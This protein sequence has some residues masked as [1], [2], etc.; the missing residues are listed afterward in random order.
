M[1]TKQVRPE[2]SEFEYELHL[3]CKCDVISK[4]NYLLFAFRTTKIFE[5][6]LYKINVT[7][8]ENLEN[9]KIAFNV[10]GLSAPKIG[11]EKYGK[12][13]FDYKLYNLNKEPYE[14]KLFRNGKTKTIY[15][16]KLIKNKITFVKK[17]HKSFLKLVME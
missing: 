4:K 16:F 14:I 9:N 1:R 15:I 13:I 2:K 7:V 17:P 11:L 12:A 6:F 3:S 8:S 5:S 10:E